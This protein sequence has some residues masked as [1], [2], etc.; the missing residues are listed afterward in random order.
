VCK[1]QDCTPNAKFCAASSLRTCAGNGLSSVETTACPQGRYCDPD[2]ASCKQ[3]YP[4]CPNIYLGSGRFGANPRPASQANDAIVMTSYDVQA[5]VAAAGQVRINNL[6]TDD[7]PS[8]HIELYLSQP[9]GN[10]PANHSQLIFETDAVVPGAAVGGAAGE[11][12][13]NWLYTFSTPGQYVLLARVANNS[14]PT[15]A[16]C[17]QQGYDTSSPATDA[18]SAIHYLN[19]SE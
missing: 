19:I 10:F 1:D 11:L 3:G 13:I 16:A 5:G 14:P 8:T 9:A 18:Q 17:I 12:A 7:S 2:S 4:S 6:G 15:G